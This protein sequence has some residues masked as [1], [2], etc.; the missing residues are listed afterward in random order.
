MTSAAAADR[1]ALSASLTVIP[2]DRQSP[3]PRPTWHHADVLDH[4]AVGEQYRHL[5]LHAPSVAGLTRPGQ[6]VMLTAARE[7][8]RGP[9]LPR[10]MAVY[11][12]DAAAGTVECVYRVVGA[13]TRRLSTFRP[14][15]R[16][17]TVG[18]LGKGFQL[19]PAA[20]RVLLVGRGIGTC[21]LTTVAQDLSDGPTEVV[22]VTSARNEANLI[23]GGLYR[24]FGAAAVH[25]VT[26]ASGSSAVE[27]LRRLLTADL[28]AS[29][30]QQIMTCGSERLA[31]LC[32]ALGRRWGADV[33]VSLEAH[34][35]CGLGYCH[36]CATGSRSGPAESPLI[37]KDGPVFRV[38]GCATGD[39][40]L[41]GTSGVR[42]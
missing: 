13:G 9:V 22:A 33:Q 29:P 30:P 8:E 2:D 1:P 20:R 37:C 16:M 17:L 21:S 14:G 38:G 6:F 19:D 3:R 35:A 31:R 40:P 27:S 25:E 12:R 5:R 15:E 39:K 32:G 28:D 42:R 7:E 41:A 18:P 10:P 36:G 23:G 4:F 34:M 26:D 24:E 11:R